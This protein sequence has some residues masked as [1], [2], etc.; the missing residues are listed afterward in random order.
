MK[1]VLQQDAD[2]QYKIG[3]QQARPAKPITALFLFFLFSFFDL[4]DEFGRLFVEVLLA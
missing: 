1:P 3:S 4:L 2:E